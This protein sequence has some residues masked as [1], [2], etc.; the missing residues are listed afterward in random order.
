[1]SDELLKL[2]LLVYIKYF[3]LINFLFAITENVIFGCVRFDGCLIYFTVGA[4]LYMN[5]C[6][7]PLL[8][9]LIFRTAPKICA[10]TLY[11]L[12]NL[13]LCLCFSLSNVVLK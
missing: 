1:M 8:E 7:H 12:A 3:D 10:F 6:I 9:T 4:L 11:E 2:Q 13:F 5:T